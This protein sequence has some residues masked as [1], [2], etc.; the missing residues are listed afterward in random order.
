MVGFTAE[1]WIRIIVITLGNSVGSILLH[2]A[3]NL[4]NH[5]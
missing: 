2:L 1:A 5:T 4:K 3:V